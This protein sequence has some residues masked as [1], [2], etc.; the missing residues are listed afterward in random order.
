MKIILLSD[1]NSIHTLKW[2]ESI[3]AN[4]FNVLLFSFFK[5]NKVSMQK[6]VHLNVKVISPD[7]KSKIKNLRKPNLSKI[8]YIKSIFLLRKTIKDYKPNIIHAHYASSY[9]IIGMLSRFRPFILSVWGSDIYFFPYRNYINRKL[10][11]YVIRYS[12]RVCSTSLAMKKIIA[13][14]YQ[15]LDVDLIPFGIDTDL[16]KLNINSNNQFTIGTIKSI[17]EHNGIDCMLEAAKIIIHDFKKEVKVLIVGAGS[18]LKEMQQKTSELNLNDN[19]TFTGY[20]P[21]ENVIKYYNKLSVFVAV[22][23]RESFGVSIL[24]AAAIGIP[25]ITSGVGGLKEV[26]IEGKTGLIVS[27]NDPMKLAQAI[28]LLYEDE[29]FRRKLGNNARKRVVENYSWENNVN[30]MINLYNEYI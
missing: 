27:P 19:V 5:P 18:L 15:R 26:N 3:K 12:D 28:L 9:G 17:E 14:E 8:R 22:S 25:S 2:V 4:N 6:Y 13:T 11:K 1:A 16:F 21:H 24:E 20:I 10:I 7:L 30:K 29:N 23:T